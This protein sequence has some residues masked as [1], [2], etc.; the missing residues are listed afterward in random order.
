MLLYSPCLER[1]FL[2]NRFFR[3]VA[4]C[5]VCGI[6]LHF[7][8]DSHLYPGEMVI[9]GIVAGV[10]YAL[11]FP[12]QKP[13]AAPKK[14]QRERILNLQDGSLGPVFLSSQYPGYKKI[15]SNPDGNDYLAPSGE[16]ICTKYE[17][18][19]LSAP[20]KQGGTLGRH[21]LCI[22]LIGLVFLYINET[23]QLSR[24]LMSKSARAVS[25]SYVGVMA[26]QAVSELQQEGWEVQVVEGE[27]D[28]EQQSGVVV[29]REID[30]QNDRITLY[31][32][33]AEPTTS[34]ADGNPVD[35]TITAAVAYVY[36][37]VEQATLRVGESVTF[38]FTCTGELP[39]SYSLSCE[40]PSSLDVEWQGWEGQSVQMQVTGMAADETNLVVELVDKES[41]AVLNSCSISV[42][43]Q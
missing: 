14:T 16:V 6:I 23:P 36:P 41:E 17:T 40:I 35:P 34:A 13:A 42:T 30:L 43:V 21:V 38:R 15:Q 26:D 2:M 27:Y 10:I 39:D 1:V 33:P 37:D 29:G 28:A 12:G 20:A 3:A 11:V 32:N 31:V 24:L 19:T 9:F 7:M 8:A 25:V 5:F 18:V 22:F 4:A